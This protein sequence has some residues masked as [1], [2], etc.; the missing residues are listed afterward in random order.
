MHDLYAMKKYAFLLI[1]LLLGV[2]VGWFLRD[3]SIPKI[4]VAEPNKTL[5][6]NVNNYSEAYGA[7]FKRDGQVF[8]GKPLSEDLTGDG[9]SELIFTTVG[10]GCGSCHAKNLYIFQR[11]KEL[12]KL[13]LDDPIFHPL[14][15]GRFVVL[16][17]IRKTD[18]GMCCP[19]TYKNILYVWDGETFSKR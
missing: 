14:S 3:S 6:E 4:E 7:I 16:E 9:Q 15:E 12:I 19:T 17:P 8:R 2:G 5:R 18:E 10:E 11:E 13:E 1:I